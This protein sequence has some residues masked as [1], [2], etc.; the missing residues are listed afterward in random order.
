MAMGQV[1]LREVKGGS[2]EAYEG[3]SPETLSESEY[4]SYE[5]EEEQE[6]PAA[7]EL[8]ELTEEEWDGLTKEEKWDYYDTL[9]REAVYEEGEG[10]EYL[11]ESISS[12]EDLQE[13][14]P[15]VYN[16]Y[17]KDE[18]GGN[19]DL[20]TD[21][22]RYV[23]PVRNQNHFSSCWA[24]GTMGAAE[25][26]LLLQDK[27][28]EGLNNK[29]DLAEKHLGYYYFN[30]YGIDDPLGNTAND[31]V[32][33][34][35]KDGRNCAYGLTNNIIQA[36]FLVKNWG[37]TAYEADYPY[38]EKDFPVKEF[39]K[40]TKNLYQNDAFH[41]K[42]IRIIY[43]NDRAEMIKQMKTAMMQYG[44][45][46]LSYAHNSK[47]YSKDKKSFYN[48]EPK[49]LN[50]TVLCV[51]W[52]DNYPADKFTG[53]DKPQNNGAW[54]IKNSWGPDQHD[55]GFFWL[56]YENKTMTQVLSVQYEGVNN[57]DNNY[58]YDGGISYTRWGYKNDPFQVANIYTV[59]GKSPQLLKAAS[60]Y[61]ASS[62]Y[63]LSLQ[64]YKNPIREGDPSSGVAMLDKP[65][66]CK[67]TSG[68]YYTLELDPKD[69][70]LLKEGDTFA[71][72]FESDKAGKY[73]MVDTEHV[74]TYKSNGNV[75]ASGISY[76]YTEKNQSL[77]RVAGD[78]NGSWYDL[79][80]K[81]RCARINGFTSNAKWYCE[82]TTEPSAAKSKKDLTTIVLNVNDSFKLD[83]T[84]A[85]DVNLTF[86]SDN[87]AVATVNS[88][89]LIKALSAGE[90]LVSVSDGV[91]TKKYYVSTVDKSKEY[92][93]NVK[94]SGLKYTG[95]AIE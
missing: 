16:A 23:S 37:G 90:A 5:T 71:L 60:I 41:V 57:Y 19:W 24:F 74:L 34:D 93:I 67:V 1:E 69:Y 78:S 76:A 52:N 17:V 92:K 27:A 73:F 85:Q 12:D 79:S 21:R 65:I 30:S 48:K 44:S 58:F 80:R 4:L 3:M 87:E 94:D 64:I 72:A 82:D 63:T 32:K 61:T 68:G 77:L 75:M 39:P 8:E 11:E 31:G 45:L 83:I 25:S 66:E 54:L 95:S 51:G 89:G 46:T 10:D 26:N 14:L 42:Q 56:S 62:D 43:N 84:K 81:N 91:Y 36:S 88:E 6:E 50:H 33:I 59:K 35:I 22:L 20:D 2:L 9:T 49:P 28:L 40:D 7:K 38:V 47:K 86:K 18:A 70:V 53:E 15:A 55:Q 29:Y 13:E